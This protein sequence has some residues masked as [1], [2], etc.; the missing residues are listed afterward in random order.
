MGEH[1]KKS[2]D[3]IPTDKHS[4]TK[5]SRCTVNRTLLPLKM[6]YFFFY[7]A[8]GAVIPFITVFMKSLNLSAAETGVVTGASVFAAAFLRTGICVVA[9]KMAARKALLMI[10]C[11]G[12]G[13]AFF[14][15]WF[16][17][18]RADLV[19]PL[20]RNQSG[21]RDTE[22][23]PASYRV[24]PFWTCFSNNGSELCRYPSSLGHT[25]CQL[26]TPSDASTLHRLRK[27]AVHFRRSFSDAHAKAGLT[28]LKNVPNLRKKRSDA[29]SAHSSNPSRQALQDKP[30]YFEHRKNERSPCFIFKEKPQNVPYLSRN[31]RVSGAKD[32]VNG[33]TDFSRSGVKG[34][35]TPNQFDRG[36]CLSDCK[37][38]TSSVFDY[39]TTAEA[40]LDSLLQDVAEFGVNFTERPWTT[41]TDLPP[42]VSKVRGVKANLDVFRAD[43]AFLVSLILVTTA[44][45]FYSSATSL[46][47]AVTYTVLGPRSLKWGRQRMWGTVGTALAVLSATNINDYLNGNSFAALFLMCLGLSFLATL[48]GIVFLRADKSPKQLSL[49]SDVSRLLSEASVRIFLVKLIFYG[50]MCGT[51]QNF[52]LWFLVDLGSNQTTL[53]LCV[54]VH[55]LSSV[56]ALRFSSRIFK[57]LSHDTV[58]RIV[59]ATYVVRFLV[60][61]FLTHA[62]TALPIE[63]LHSITYSL[64][65]AAA[66]STASQM[67]PPGTQASC[68]AIAGATYWD[69]GRGLGNLMTGQLMQAMG[70]RWTFRSYAGACA[71]L[72]PVFWLLDRAWPIARQQLVLPVSTCEGDFK[73]VLSKDNSGEPLNQ[74]LL[75]ENEKSSSVQD[76][77]DTKNG[78]EEDLLNCTPATTDLGGRREG[79]ND[80]P[81]FLPSAG[82]ISTSILDH[83]NTSIT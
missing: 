7:G 79:E 44:R 52:F 45:A 72:L 75:L 30:Y 73:E 4:E 54:A 25:T 13:I 50:I 81:N 58:I 67:A 8:C 74:Q 35:E 71:L 68:Q 56:F 34:K 40:S 5:R 76:N 39:A 37:L 31:R 1:G 26:L 20:V 43:T 47:D 33:S 49:R 41:A 69:L 78:A 38:V 32:I 16:I 24:P 46:A 12:F 42:I 6:F 15:L 23:L 36:I 77:D 10:S 80:F 17:P 65:W 55:C 63:V 27:R 28:V 48:V 11:F 9:D 66:S 61:S 29:L 18:P 57:L 3:G 19:L 62:W 64:M 22:S 51:A 60:F 2:P 53:G 59:L 70:A 83:V 82:N 21:L 14:F